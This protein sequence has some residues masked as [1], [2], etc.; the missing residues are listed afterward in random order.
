MSSRDVKSQSLTVLSSDPEAI[1]LV[2]GLKVHA[3]IQW[4]WAWIEKRN[5]LSATLVTFNYLSSEPESN[6]WPLVEK[7]RDL[8]VLEC[9]LTTWECPSTVLFQSLIVLSSEHDAMI[10]PYGETLTSC[11]AP[12]CPTNLNG[13]IVDLKFHTITVPSYEPDITYFKF[14]L[15]ATLLTYSLCPLKDLFSAGSPAG[16]LSVIFLYFLNFFIW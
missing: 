12:L 7:Q 16:L 2:S 8:T 11:T 15:K 3:L 6:I 9:V 5:F 10:L 1:N 14:G 13:L 4:L